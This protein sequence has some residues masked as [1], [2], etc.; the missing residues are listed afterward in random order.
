MWDVG[1]IGGGPAG[2][3][4]ARRLAR[5]GLSVLLVEGAR[6]P[7]VKPCG[8]ALTDRALSLLPEGAD[9][10]WKSHPR[11]WTFRTRSISPVTVSRGKAYCHTVI[12]REF[13]Q[14]LFERAADAGAV[15]HDG[16]RVT[17]VEPESG[18]FVLRTAKDRYRVRYVVGADGA[19]GVTAKA[20]GIPRPRMGAALEVEEPAPASLLDAYR[21]R[22]EVMVS[23]APWG[24]CWVIP[25][26]DQL[27]IGVG[28]FH[29]V[30]F[31]WRERLERYCR[32]LGFQRRGPVLAHPLPYRWSKVRL[33][34]G[35]ALVVGD[36]AGLMDPFSAEGIYAA[37]W[38]ATLAAEVLARAAAR[39]EDLSAY[40]AAL[41]ETV[42]PDLGRAGVLA[43][44][45]YTMPGAWGRFFTRDTTLLHTYLDV[46]D[47]RGG[48]EAL[49]RA[50]REHW[51]RLV[52]RARPSPAS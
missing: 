50:T 31:S 51:W 25:K 7:R 16:E 4:A 34:R 30:G 29:A 21:D 38:S 26:G 24:Y 46:L 45:F 52:R 27:N 28:S 2:S 11:Q 32:E 33:Q 43:R 40:D 14:F 44:L 42:W 41:A 22:C 48:Y 8:G 47:G 13:D 17:G 37:L 12:R 1:V 23:D 5:E 20:L 6:H 3:T 9:G 35:R 19:K 36:A 15:L 39:D 18:R 10:L 49:L